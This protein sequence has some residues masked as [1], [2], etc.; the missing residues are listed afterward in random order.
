VL[1]SHDVEHGLAEADLVLGL[2][3]G[4]QELLAPAAEVGV[5]D[6]RRLYA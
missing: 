5:D 2:R 6:L 3:G 1:I 4:R